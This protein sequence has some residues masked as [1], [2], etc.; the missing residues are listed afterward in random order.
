MCDTAKTVLL[1]Q[2][3]EKEGAVQESAMF[4]SSISKKNIQCYV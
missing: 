4:V 3:G 1:C 2:W